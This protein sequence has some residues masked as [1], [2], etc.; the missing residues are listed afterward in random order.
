[1]LA[2]LHAVVACGTN[3]YK[4][5]S[6]PRIE[7][8]YC[9]LLLLLLC[10]FCFRKCL[11]KCYV[12]VAHVVRSVVLV[13]CYLYATMQDVQAINFDSLLILNQQSESAQ[14]MDV[15]DMK[16]F[17]CLPAEASNSESINTL[18]PKC[19]TIRIVSVFFSP[20]LLLLLFTS[21][22]CVICIEA[23]VKDKFT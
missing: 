12:N 16:Y 14:R 6:L 2:T 15:K 18:P 17:K 10:V 1:M 21:P 9:A 23:F 13:F 8:C 4:F 5:M 20:S 3:N 19:K 22:I 11:K 7:K